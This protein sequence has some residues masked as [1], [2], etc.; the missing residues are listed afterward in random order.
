M[1][2]VIIVGRA[3]KDPESK[4]SANGNV[5]AKLRMAIDGRGK[6]DEA[7]FTTITLFGKQAELTIQY[8]KK[9]RQILIEGRLQED[10]WEDKNGETRTS[11]SIVGERIEFLGPNP[12]APATNNESVAATTNG[13]DNPF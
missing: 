9:G 10:R 3:C 2:R 1:N 12:N 5:F 11:L 13:E 6:D 7:L 4:T 8:V